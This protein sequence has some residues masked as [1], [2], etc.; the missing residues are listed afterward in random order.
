MRKSPADARN[1]LSYEREHDE[2]DVRRT[3][4]RDIRSSLV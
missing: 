3:G 1:C 2:D 4:R